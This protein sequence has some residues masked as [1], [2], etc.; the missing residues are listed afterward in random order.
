MYNTFSSDYDRFVNWRNRLSME[1]PFLEEEIDRAFPL[2][3]I[4]IRILDAA[5]GTGMHA[6]ELSKLGFDVCGADL[7]EGM[8]Q[9]ARMNA[10]AN[11]ANL[12]FEATGFGRLA[13]TFEIG[14]TSNP[15]K[16]DQANFDVVL[17]LGNSL[18]HVTTQQDLRAALQDFASC[19]GQDG[20]LI[21]QNRNF[22]A[23]MNAKERWMEPQFYKEK[24]RE[25][26]FLRFYDYQPDGLINFNIVTLARD[27]VGDWKQSVSSTTLMPLLSADL[28]SALQT[29]GFT[30]IHFYGDMLRSP[31]DQETSGNLVITARKI[32]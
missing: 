1:L 25:W 13:R 7:S 10:M 18:P 2:K 31:Y 11:N 4:P 9:R 27:G 17:C 29:T 8:I 15:T 23:L 22:N 24:T 12:R 20:L 5:T 30:D 3:N 26:L 21:L 14:S 28:Q 6:I 32:T 16:N 19:L